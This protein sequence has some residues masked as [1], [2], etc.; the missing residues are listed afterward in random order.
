MSAYGFHEKER[1]DNKEQSLQSIS[2]IAAFFILLAL[3]KLGDGM[4]FDVLSVMIVDNHDKWTGVTEYT[5]TESSEVVY[6]LG[7][8][9][10]WFIGC[11]LLSLL[12]LVC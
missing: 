7:G 8:V 10:V 1:V 9:S 6:Q 4:A 11:W 3:Q 12:W 2:V 5:Y